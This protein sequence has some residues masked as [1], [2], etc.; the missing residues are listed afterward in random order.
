MANQEHLGILKQGVKVWND[1]RKGH[2]D[3]FLSP[4]LTSASLN[5]TVLAGVNFYRTNLNNARLRGADL[6]GAIL[7]NAFFVRAELR[8]ATLTNARL[9]AA[10][11]SR[12]DLRSA[13]WTG[14]TPAPPR[15]SL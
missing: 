10:Q 15:P 4:N 1:W 5:N 3:P 6:T 14:R 9:T 2:P 12:A 7:V 13:K 8:D 11:L